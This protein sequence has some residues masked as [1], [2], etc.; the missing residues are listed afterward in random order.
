MALIAS[1]G[2]ATILNFNTAGQY[3]IVS[4]SREYQVKCGCWSPKGKQIVLGFADGKLQQF[5]PNLTPARLLTCPSNVHPT[6][7]DTIAVHWLS[8]FQFAAIFLQREEG[9]SPFL[10]IIN[11]PK[12]GQISYV[13]YYDVCYSASGPRTH[14]INFIHIPQWNLILLTSA[15]GVEVGVLGTREQG[16]NPNWIQYNLL[17]EARIE[18]PLT[19]GKDETYPMGITLDTSCTHQLIIKESQMP[20]MPMIHLLSTHGQLISFDFLNMT[21]GINGICSPPPPVVDKSGQ[22]LPLQLRT[23]SEK[24]QSSMTT[25]IPNNAIK[26]EDNNTTFVMN[27]QITTSTPVVVSDIH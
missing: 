19:E 22:F 18:L 11:A 10:F 25:A 17:D 1:D 23:N 21:Q 15:N 16:D 3:D 14:Q 24:Q 5:K 12:S 20:I 8:T 9:A 13:N 7:F 2:S 26:K 27:N 4:L 6:P